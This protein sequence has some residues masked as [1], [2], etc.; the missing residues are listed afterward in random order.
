MYLRERELFLRR[1]SKHKLTQR[2]PGFLFKNTPEI[3][4]TRI[5]GVFTQQTLSYLVDAA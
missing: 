5:S 3:P 4:T 1:L 2:F